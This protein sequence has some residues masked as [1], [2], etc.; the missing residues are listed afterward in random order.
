[1]SA[2][3]TPAGPVLVVAEHA[4]GSLLP[5]T[6][7]L[8]SAGRQLAAL[9]GRQL[10]LLVLAADPLPLARQAA[11]LSG[12]RVL[13][14]RID[15][16]DHFLG[17]AYQQALAALL[18][19]RPAAALLAGHASQGLDW[20]PGL[21]LRLGGS[22]V[23]GVEEISGQAG[24]PRL[25]RASHFGK[26]REILAPLAW[27]LCLTVQPGAFAAAQAGE[28]PAPEVELLEMEP[29][30]CPV[31]LLAQAAGAQADAALAQAQ[32][33]VAGGR[34]LGKAENLELLRRLAALFGGAALAGSRPVCD[35][36]WLGYQS[37]VGLTGASVTPRLYIA[38]GISGARQH[39]VGMQGS[40]FIVAMNLDPQAAIFSVADVG[41]AADLTVF[42]P[43]LI[44]A[45]ADQG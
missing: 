9:L 32:V 17:Q 24:A 37:Q 27:P 13:A 29:P 25:A 40:G 36:G 21:S 7:E 35:L 2:P 4:G 33:V 16:L 19:Q 30:P 42:I 28:K 43:A 38:C 45:C 26:A 5:L 8:V 41:V 22:L 20:L 12:E 1:M 23:T 18:E 3:P 10:R 44:E 39:T 11:C 31:R 6:L 14:L 15:G 34:G